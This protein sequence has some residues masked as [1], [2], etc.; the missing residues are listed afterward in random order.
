MPTPIIT[1]EDLVTLKAARE[2]LTRIHRKAADAGNP[3]TS[4]AAANAIE[5]LDRVEIRR[6]VDAN[7]PTTLRDAR[8]ESGFVKTF[9]V[10]AAREM[11]SVFNTMSLAPRT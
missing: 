10:E 6:G 4:V 3:L 1:A 2:A 8:G 5:A 9:G 7:A 11:P